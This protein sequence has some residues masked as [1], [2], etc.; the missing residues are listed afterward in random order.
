[1]LVSGIKSMTGETFGAGGTLSVIAAVEMI[2]R[3]FIPRINGLSEPCGT[4]L[5]LTLETSLEMKVESVI[6]NSI[7]SGGIS[8][9][10]VLIQGKRN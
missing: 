9:S 2:G 1:M 7:D 3:G 8:V 4:G 10:T 6:I 5:N